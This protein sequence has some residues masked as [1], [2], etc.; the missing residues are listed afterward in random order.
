MLSY[1]PLWKTLIEKNMKKTDLCNAVGC[2]RATL[3]KMSRDE[4]VSMAVIDKI[5][6]YLGC[7][8]ED[9]IRVKH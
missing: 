8:I 5:C 2:S 3:A 7:E 9:V 6:V 1:I 4:Y